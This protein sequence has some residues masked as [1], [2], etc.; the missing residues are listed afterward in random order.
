MATYAYGVCNLLPPYKVCFTSKH[1]SPVIKCVTSEGV[2]HFFCPSAIYYLR[3]SSVLGE[4]LDKKLQNL[5]ELSHKGIV[6]SGTYRQ[7]ST[8]YTVHCTVLGKAVLSF[9][10]GKYIQDVFYAFTLIRSAITA[11]TD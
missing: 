3:I 11:N 7:T 8:W 6:K 9:M 5:H 4:W 1:L 2:F 10:C